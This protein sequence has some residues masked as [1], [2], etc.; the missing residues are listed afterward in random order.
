MRAGNGVLW[1]TNCGGTL[2]E[3]AS[4]RTALRWAC[5][6]TCTSRK[7]TDAVG[8]FPGEAAIARFARAPLRERSG[9]WQLQRR[10]LQL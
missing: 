6:R 1:R 3:S 9:E 5:G 2:R 4:S 10:H 7:R 8:I